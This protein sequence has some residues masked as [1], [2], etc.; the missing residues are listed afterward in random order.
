MNRAA[1]WAVAAIGIGAFL[2]AFP[3]AQPVP[4]T[5]WQLDRA[6]AHSKAVAALKDLLQVDARGWDWRS[7]FE[8]RQYLLLWQTLHGRTA[9]DFIGSATE[10]KMEFTGNRRE[11]TVWLC[12]DGRLCGLQQSRDGRRRTDS[13]PP[14]QN[15]WLAKRI[16]EAMAGKDAARFRPSTASMDGDYR[17]EL[18]TDSSELVK[19]EIRVRTDSRGLRD[20]RLRA[21]V[22]QSVRA[23]LA[24]GAQATGETT[25][26]VSA[27]LVS[28]G[29]SAV[30]MVFLFGAFRRRL[31]WK[32]ALT[33]GVLYLASGLLP[34]A[35]G[36]MLPERG[37]DWHIDINAGVVFA[38]L[39]VMASV[40]VG[41]GWARELDWNRWTTFRLFLQRKWKARSLGASVR[42]GMAW[43]GVL[44]AIPLLV[45]G[46]GLFPDTL[47][48]ERN[49]L[50]ALMTN[51]PALWALHPWF[52][53]ASFG[54]YVVALPFL[55]AK[56]GVRAAVW[57]LF[58]PVAGVL[59]FLRSPLGGG[60][61]G[62]AISAAG[63]AMV[64]VLLYLRCD[65]TAT[66]AAAKG[67]LL[68]TQAM[69]LLQGPGSAPVH[70]WIAL[71]AF[72]GLFTAAAVL[73]RT[74][75][76]LQPADPIAA[77]FLSEREKLKAEF[78]LAQQAQQ[79]LLPAEPPQVAGFSV[80]ASC[81]PAREVGGDL[82]DYF[83]LADGRQGF[84][85][86][87]VSGKGMPAALYM[88]LTKG[89]L[90]AAAPESRELPELAK[91]VNQHLYTACKR[92]MFVTAV[93]ASLEPGSRQVELLRAGHNAPLV[94][95]AGTGIAEYRKPAGLGLGLTSAALFT[96]GTKVEN[97]QLEPGD[98][99]ILYSDGVTE[100]MNEKLELYGEDRLKAVVEERSALSAAQLVEEIRRDIGVFA[101]A[102]PAH[103]DITLL[104]VR[105]E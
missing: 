24:R 64:S 31:D 47:W 21:N 38:A 80:A 91:H 8:T 81:Q 74:G 76:E 73:A 52:E 95:R 42:D 49:Y 40:S 46:S 13:G 79:R 16:F 1:W 78:G 62:A 12:A 70:G 36:T 14:G 22:P 55:S 2:W 3:K 63:T 102:E 65:L 97:L 94:Y 15:E 72:G 41:E 6:A 57:F 68:L 39:A 77:Q 35:V 103:D 30:T 45:A 104:V 101:G 86:A 61:N 50:P 4:A 98:S 17:W 32:S 71:A 44:A 69:V 34:H 48:S 29:A 66:L 19:W 83:H 105:A 87:D 28:V 5:R 51:V 26:I 89:L 37:V 93:M 100:A 59:F 18:A 20:A 60:L 84:C 33:A 7:E 67:G 10:L 9:G 58:L 54:L 11:G 90:A 53:L 85:V 27:V 92:K 23:G 75:E 82:Y 56:L 25:R 96:R 99:L 43:S 88:T